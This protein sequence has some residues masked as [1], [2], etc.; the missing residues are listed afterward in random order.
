MY[1]NFY[2][3]DIFYTFLFFI[4]KKTI[5]FVPQEIKL[6]E[7]KQLQLYIISLTNFIISNKSNKLCQFFYISELWISCQNI[8]IHSRQK[9][10][11]H[12]I[13]AQF[14]NIFQSR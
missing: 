11:G 10:M 3:S 14:L 2:T 6:K 5:S 12:L 8:V 4:I 9:R 1:N 7:R 13:S